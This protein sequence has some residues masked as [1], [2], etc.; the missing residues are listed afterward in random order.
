MKGEKGEW[1]RANVRSVRALNGSPQSPFLSPL[2]TFC[3]TSVLVFMPN[4][5]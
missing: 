4:A 5:V 2:Q 1:S 3:F